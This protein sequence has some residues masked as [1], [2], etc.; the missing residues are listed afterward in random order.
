MSRSSARRAGGRAIRR[1]QRKSNTPLIVGAVAVGLVILVAAGLALSRG[2]GASAGEQFP[3]MVSSP[4]IE[5]LTAAHEPYNSNPPTSGPHVGNTAPAGISPQPLPDELTTHNLEHGFVI[6]HYRQDLD[7][8]AVERLTALMR[9]LQ[10]ES[11][12]IVMVPRP[13]DKLDVAVAVTAWTRLLKLQT[14][15]EAAI[16]SFFEARV[17]RGPEQICT[18]L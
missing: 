14:V 2:G 8:A 5:S 7:Q 4:H 3:E 10:R 13:T 1:P 12:C 11:P 17:G 16:R 15:D 18:P 6:I 9:Q